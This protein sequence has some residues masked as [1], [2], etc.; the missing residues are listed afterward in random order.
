M[1]KL[2]GL[3]TAMTFALSVFFVSNTTSN[4]MDLASLMSL[5]SANA[6]CV[7]VSHTTFYECNAYDRCVYIGAI[8]NHGCL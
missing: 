2:I 3:I 4:D 1:K 5:N 7:G 8:T 6:E